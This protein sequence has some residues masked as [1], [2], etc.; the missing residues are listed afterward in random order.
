MSGPECC[1]NPPSLNPTS[2]VG[3]VEEVSG[4]KAYVTGSAYSNQAVLLVSDV[5]G[6]EAANLRKLADKVTAARFYVV[7][8]DFFH[9]DPYDPQNAERPL[10]VWIKDHGPDKGFEDAKRILE[11]LKSKGILTVGAAGFCW[12]AKVVVELSK[13]GL[14]QA[15]VLLH[16]TFVTVDDIKRVKIFPKV[17]H[18]WTV[19]Y[20]VEDEFVVKSAEEAHKDAIEWFSKYLKSW[21]RVLSSL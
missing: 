8:P 20:K 5:Y 16:P 2:V 7:I 4:F 17:S 3:H 19:R 6:Y 15:A 9:G 14:I 12:G 1:S 18:G 21:N 11:S 10:P 13:L